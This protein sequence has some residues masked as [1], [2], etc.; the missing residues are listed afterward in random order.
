MGKYTVIADVGKSIVDMLKDQLI[1]EPVSKPDTI[2]I[3]DP[4]E[5][6]SFVVGIHPYNF[7]ENTEMRRIDPVVLPD[8]NLQNPPG[9]Y[10]IFYMISVASKSE[11]ATKA[12][13]EQRILGKIIQV[14]RDNPR[15]PKKYMPE[16][17]RLANEDISIEM[18]NLELEE[19]VKIWT[20]FSEPYKLSIFYSVG[21][22][23]IDSEVIKAPAKR[24]TSFG[25]DK[26]KIVKRED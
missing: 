15:I 18:L 12:E 6:G 17:L 24:V 1:P 3:C 14:L 10:Q 20:M 9:S 13:D 2:G 4:K 22:L 16:T 11:Q 25:I 26:R 5:R 23:F 8:G 7:K 19:K 21:P